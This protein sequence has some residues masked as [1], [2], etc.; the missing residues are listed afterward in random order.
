MS[1]AEEWTEN[2]NGETVKVFKTNMFF[3]SPQEVLAAYFKHAKPEAQILIYAKS[4][5]RKE[6]GD[7]LRTVRFTER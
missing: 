4:M 6:F 3:G 2:V 1:V 5:P 7:L